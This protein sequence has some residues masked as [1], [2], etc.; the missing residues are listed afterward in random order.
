MC[1]NV[2]TVSAEDKDDGTGFEMHGTFMF[3]PIL[4][5]VCEIICCFAFIW[6]SWIFFLPNTEIMDPL[7][8]FSSSILR[9]KSRKHW[10]RQAHSEARWFKRLSVQRKGREYTPSPSVICYSEV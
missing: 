4:L 8:S 9:G 2:S 3:S 1:A 10:G 6:W 7:F 5:E